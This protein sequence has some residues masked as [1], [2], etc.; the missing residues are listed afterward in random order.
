MGSLLR[1][2]PLLIFLLLFLALCLPNTRLHAESADESV[3][4]SRTIVVGGDR[5]YP[6]YEFIDKDGH[7][8]GYN[9]DLTRAIADVMGMKVAFRFGSWS[10]MRH[11]LSNGSI[12]ILQGISWSEERAKKLDFSPPHTIVHHAVFA[13]REPRP[14][15][16]W[17][18]C[19]ARRSS[20]SAT[21][22]CTTS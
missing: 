14:S 18:N 13:G 16:L 17:R 19:G 11:G 1:V 7:P 6:P 20:F 4:D 22:S 10:E 9:V 12:N 15:P 2:K 5:D 3:P 21:A 8:A